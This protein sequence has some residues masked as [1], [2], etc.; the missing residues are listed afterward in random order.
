MDYTVYGILQ[1]TILEWVAC[2]LLQGIFPTQELS[3]SLPHSRGIL[4][5]MSHR[6]IPWILE[7][8]AC[9]FSRGSSWPRNW[10]GV[11]CIAG[12][13]FTNWAI[14]EAPISVIQF[15]CSVESDSLWL[16][17]LQHARPPRPS[18]SPGVHPNR[19]TLS[20][21][22]H[23]AISSS[24]IPFSSCPQSFPALRSFQM[25]QLIVSGGQS[26]GVSA[27]TSVLP[28]NT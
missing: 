16:H 14:R 6:G 18:P 26:I 19:Y 4:Y 8:V 9:P 5:Q 3:P 7:C 13:F 22:C 2:S 12:R 20:R 23:P 17:G 24:V 10:T 28:M 27:S 21:W 25:S 11:F 15:S 1:A